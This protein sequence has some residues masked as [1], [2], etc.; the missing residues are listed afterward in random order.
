M[1]RFLSELEARLVSDDK[2]WELITPLGFYSDVLSCEIWAPAKFRTDFSSI[3]RWIPLI[4][5]ILLDKA[6]R[7]GVIHDFIYCKDSVPQVPRDLSD[8]VIREAMEV[9]GK[10]WWMRQVVYAGVRAGGWAYYHKRNV[11]V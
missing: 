10:P 6:H 7:E 11:F 3:P 5:N 9:R 2:Y 8:Q 4:S 1:A